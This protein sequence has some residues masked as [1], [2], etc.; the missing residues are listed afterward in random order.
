MRIAYVCQQN[1]IGSNAGGPTYE[2][3]LISAIKTD[4]HELD[5][6]GPNY[7]ID[8]LQPDLFICCDLWNNPLNRLV[9]WFQQDSINKTVDGSIKYCTFDCGYST[10]C[11]KDYYSCNGVYFGCSPCFCRGERLGFLQKY[12][13]NALINIFLSPLHRDNIQ[14]AIDYELPNVILMRPP[15]DISV[16]YD[17]KL[18]RDIDV[19][20]VGVV[21][22]SKGF[23]YLINEYGN[24]N[25]KVVVIGDNLWLH[26]FPNNFQYIQKI[27]RE[28]LVD[29]YNRAK[30]F[31]S[32]SRW[33]EPFGLT[34]AE[35]TLC[36]CSIIGNKNSGALSWDVDLADCNFY[37]ESGKELWQEI[38]KKISN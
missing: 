21:S 6:Y 8:V 12:Y 1:P 15:V 22:E 14:K 29:Y 27:P 34:T 25:K 20:Y 10:I 23:H 17:R 38:L 30:S 33:F 2:N 37:K 9:N 28:Q 18:E 3:E 26:P 31:W 4:N 5:I 16:F 24:T 36:G 11:D 32:K 19:L 7:Y 35:A 13:A